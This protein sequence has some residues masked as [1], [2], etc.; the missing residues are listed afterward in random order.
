MQSMK[1]KSILYYTDCPFFGGCENMIAN[2]LNDEA[3]AEQFNVEFLYRYSEIYSDTLY[4]RV[5]FKHERISS[6]NLPDPSSVHN[7]FKRK[8]SNRFLRIIISAP[9]ILI[10]KYICIFYSIFPLYKY[11]KNKEIDILHINNGGFPGAISCY[12]IV[13]AARILGIKR[14]V[15][16]VNNIA[17]SYKSP[18]RWIDFPLDKLIR[19]NVNIFITGSQHA[20]TALINTLNLKKE[21]AINIPNGISPRN[22]TQDYNEFRI[23]NNFSKTKIVFT[24]I[25]IL[26]KRKG[27]SVLLN[28]IKIL[29]DNRV[30]GM[31]DFPLFVIEGV[32][33]EMDNIVNFIKDN[34]LNN[35]VILI[36]EIRNVFNLINASDVIVLPSVSNEDF[37]NIILEAMMLS[38]PVIGTKI[39][40]IPEQIADNINGYLIDPSNPEQLALAIEK[41]LNNEIRT[42]FSKESLIRFNK[43]FSLNSSINSYIKIYNQLL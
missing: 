32:G 9:L 31:D 8:I 35:E 43:L 24:V 20:R 12:S 5:P 19:S 18:L 41:L 6:I 34:N 42:E 28:A 40:G 22:I 37:P 2:F 30:N 13:F 11:L 39:A 33:S 23:S 26:E 29:K 3:I 36:G 27:H 17:A 7:Y 21:K 4:K 38:K 1:N 16:V 15:Y 14:I 25:A 10:W